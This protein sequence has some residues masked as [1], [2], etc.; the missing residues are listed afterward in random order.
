LQVI[1]IYG[2][3]S[4][5]RSISIPFWLPIKDF[6]EI[7]FLARSFRTIAHNST[8]SKFSDEKTTHLLNTKMSTLSPEQLTPTA[9]TKK[10]PRNELTTTESVRSLRTAELD[11]NLHASIHNGA[12]ATQRLEIASSAE[13]SS[14]G[15]LSDDDDDDDEGSFGEASDGSKA[16]ERYLKRGMSMGQ[17]DVYDLIQE[18]RNDIAGTEEETEFEKEVAAA[19]AQVE[20][21]ALTGEWKGED[22]DE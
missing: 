10:D 2:N 20:R 4:R 9:A 5:Q 22:D 14:H 13:E 12:A 16:D 19:L 8:A 11:T 3:K 1:Y 15:D 7:P 21:Q 17:D 18:Y 6:E